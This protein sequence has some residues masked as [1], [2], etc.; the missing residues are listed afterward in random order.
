MSVDVLRAGVNDDICT[1]LER[2]CE[3]RCG[4]SVAA[5]DLDLRV[6]LMRDG[7]C[8][9]YICDLESRVGRCLKI[10]DACLP[11]LSRAVYQAWKSA[12]S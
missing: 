5:D 9:A 4:E 12:E 7:R 11:L 3:I 10:D 1:E 8:F 2:L 6:I